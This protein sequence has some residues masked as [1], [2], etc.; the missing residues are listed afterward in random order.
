MEIP[1]KKKTFVPEP[2]KKTIPRQSKTYFERNSIGKQYLGEVYNTNEKKFKNKSRQ[3]HRYETLEV[4][5]EKFKK[6]E[7]KKN[8]QW[9]KYRE[10]QTKYNDIMRSIAKKVI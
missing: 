8:E 10:H 5:K 4:I 1:M 6:E 7:D 2:D 9:Q 3:L